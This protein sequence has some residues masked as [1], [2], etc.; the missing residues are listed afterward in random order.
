M[1]RRA[2]KAMGGRFEGQV[3]IVTGAARGLGLGIAARLAA[4]G[5]RVAVWDVDPAGFDP[6]AAGFAP[7]SVEAVDVTGEAAVA[8]ATARV[9]RQFGRLDVL[10][11]NAGING[12][13]APVED[14]RLEDWRRVLDV[15]LTGVFLCCRAAIAPMKA[16]GYGRIVNV[17]SIA[18]KEG[19]PGI[20][21]Y[22]AAKAGVIG[23]TRSLARELAGS[24]ILVNAVAPA[25]A[26]TGLL[27]QMTPEHI[28]ASRARIPMNRLLRVE[29]LAAVVAFA[30]SPECSFTTGFTFDA[31]GGRA[32][33]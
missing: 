26:E 6:E 20:A 7:A 24:G 3:A 32:D 17:A 23:F 9:A 2:G 19:V 16:K 30:A 31:S 21:A 27:S 13:V 10:V 15:D 14:Y 33:Y 12:P 5:A 28:A 29:E 1:S 4:E 18:G 22:A 8:A 11:C 25:M